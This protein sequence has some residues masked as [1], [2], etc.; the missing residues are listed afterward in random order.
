MPLP[1]LVV[2]LDGYAG[3]ASALERLD[4]GRLLERLER[5][6]PE[7]PAAG[8]HF[9]ITADRRAAIPSSLASVVTTRLVLRM[10]ERDDYALLGVDSN[11]SRTA[12][13]APG[14]GFI[15]G[16]TEIQVAVVAGAAPEV[17]QQALLDLVRR[18]ADR[19]PTPAPRLRR[20][21]STVQVRELPSAPAPLVLPIGVGDLE[22]APVVVDATQ[23]HWLVSGPP[24]SGKS[25]TLA[26]LAVVAAAAP[27]AAALALF[28]ARRSS[29]SEVAAWRVGPVDAGDGDALARGI[30]DVEAL[31]ARGEPV[32]CLC[33]DVDSFPE[34]ASSA[35]EALARRGRDEPV[36]VVASADNRWALRAYGGLV[37]EV[38]RS[39]QALLLCPDVD[40][41]GDLVGVRLRPPLEVLTGPGRGFLV[42]TGHAELVQIAHL[43]DGEPIHARREPR[44]GSLEYRYAKDA[45]GMS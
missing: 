6:V 10:A 5:L 11:L 39:K 33:D 28:Q 9:V 19:W 20:M 36:R 41:D 24:R 31:L 45:E 14:R 21:P 1:R 30:A 29:L 25:S 44:G 35:L 23:G 3:A 12:V 13:L 26:S 16:S 38:R 22:V 15:Q 43:G 37:P 32:L 27:D 40:L 34:A 7:G 8:V 42:Q 2:L 17:E 18:A 4:G